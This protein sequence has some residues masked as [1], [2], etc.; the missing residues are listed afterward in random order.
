MKYVPVHV[1]RERAER[2]AESM[3]DILC[4]LRGFL[5]AS[6]VDEH[7]I[8]RM[9]IEDASRFNADLKDALSRSPAYDIEHPLQPLPF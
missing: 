1:P 8:I 4:W 7:Q 5:A 9:A 2:T 3:S 6:P